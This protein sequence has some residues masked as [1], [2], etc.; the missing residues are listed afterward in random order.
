MKPIHRKL[1]FT[2][3]AI[4]M[5]LAAVEA[6][7]RIAE[8]VSPPPPLR[9]LPAPGE[10]ECMPDCM[11]GV[12][13]LPDQPS[14]LPRGIPMAPNGRRAWALPSNTTMVET[15]VAVRVNADGLRGPDLSPRGANEM[16]LLTLGDSSVFGFGVEEDRV[17]GAVASAELSAKW[18]RPVSDINGGTPG[19]TSV[20]ALAVL[21]DVGTRAQPT[22]V[23]IATLWSDLFQTDTVLERAGGQR[24]PLAAYRVAARVLAPWLP[25]ATV[26]WTQ[27]DVGAEAPGRTARVGIEQYRRTLE[28]IVK[29]TRAIGA[30]PV[31][32]V[33]PAPID[34]DQQPVPDLIEAYRTELID[35]ARR[36]ALIVV[37][38]PAIFKEEGATN[39]DFYDQVHPSATGHERLGKALAA[40]LLNTNAN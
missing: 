34:L 25:A 2:F 32:L 4:F 9:P 6:L 26:G 19:Y 13:V 24:A 21:E 17:F 36:H 15:N 33:L 10:A 20:Q 3:F 27:G 31:V 22:H 38:G 35:L 28:Q 1:G 8:R 18:S 30:E 11:P 14:G 5:G 37:D 29:T 23:V 7:A 16:R 39:A 40:A 12:A